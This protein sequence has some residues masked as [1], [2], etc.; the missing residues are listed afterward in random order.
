MVGGQQ[1]STLPCQKQR[2]PPCAHEARVQG[3]TCKTGTWAPLHTWSTGLNS[4]PHTPLRWPRITSAG[5][6]E[7]IRHVLTSRSAPAEASKVP[8]GASARAL[9]SLACAAVADSV[10]SLRGAAREGHKENPAVS[11]REPACLCGPHKSLQLDQRTTHK[12]H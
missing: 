3:F 1:T 5:A 2:F 11:A 9:T 12:T 7:G 10:D 4:T 6:S 8:F